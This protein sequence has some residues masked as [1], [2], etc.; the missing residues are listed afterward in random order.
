M[1][2]EPL[3][4]FDERRHNCR[5]QLERHKRRRLEH[6]AKDAI[7]TPARRGEEVVAT[8]CRQSGETVSAADNI[9]GEVDKPP[10]VEDSHD[11]EVDVCTQGSPTTQ[12][13]DD[14]ELSLEPPYLCSSR[15]DMLLSPR[16]DATGMLLEPHQVADAVFLP[17]MHG[18]PRFAQ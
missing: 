15:L 8:N 17:A 14:A 16:F 10:E 2:V 6:M 1:R 4:E 12:E 3:S 5:R 18:M 7:A 11:M 13:W 9:G